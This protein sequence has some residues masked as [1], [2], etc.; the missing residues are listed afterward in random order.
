MHK[1]DVQFIH[2]D[3]QPV[4][5]VMSYEKYQ[6]LLN[7]AGKTMSANEPGIPHAVVGLVV[8]EGLTPIRAWRK[9]LRLTQAEA[10]RRLNMSQAAF[11]QIEKAGKNHAET[12]RKIAAAFGISPAQL[13]WME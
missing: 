9:H 1:Q 2:Q 10:A 7:L 12:L 8:L 13:E 6:Q 4:A 11:A 5:V 3:D